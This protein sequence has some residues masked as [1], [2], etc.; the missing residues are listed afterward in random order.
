MLDIDESYLTREKNIIQRRVLESD[1]PYINKK[2]VL[3]G[4]KQIRYP[5]FHLDFESFNCPLPRF[6][7]EVPY[8]QSVFQFSLHIEKEEGICDL[9]KDHFGFLAKDHDDHRE[10]LI[11][12]MCD[13][14]GDGTVLVYNDSF[15]KTRIKEFAEMFPKYRK[16]LLKI[17]DQVFDLMNVVKTRS[18]LYK[19]L[20]YSD[21]EAKMF[22]Y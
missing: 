18:K 4:L 15:E 21:E 19:E 13:L 20:G 16:E 14:I 7:G 12:K 1:I 2:K 6:K 11:K 3:D 10:E 8:S 22:N 17:N 5:I 9:E